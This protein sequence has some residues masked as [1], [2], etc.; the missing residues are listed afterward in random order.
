MTSTVAIFWTHDTVLR[1]SDTV[2]C[3]TG[4]QNC[5]VILVSSARGSFRTSA[6]SRIWISSDWIR[7]RT[8]GAVAAVWRSNQKEVTIV[9]TGFAIDCTE[10]NCFTKH[11]RHRH[12]VPRRLRKGPQNPWQQVQKADGK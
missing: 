5:D 12:M 6:P 8:W 7:P 9:D 4:V 2:V 1:Y 3:E 11:L 10:Q